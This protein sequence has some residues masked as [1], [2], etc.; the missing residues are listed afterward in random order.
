MA[1]RTSAQKFLATLN[2]NRNLDSGRQFCSRYHSV[3]VYSDG[4][5]SGHKWA[6]GIADNFFTA[7]STLGDVQTVLNLLAKMGRG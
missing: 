7:P 6:D 1:K 3:R 4:S 2:R 5:M